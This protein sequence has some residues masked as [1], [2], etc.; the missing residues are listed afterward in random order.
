[1]SLRS[2]FDLIYKV[3]GRK[4]VWSDLSAEPAIEERDP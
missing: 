4:L 1:M 2:E 3:E